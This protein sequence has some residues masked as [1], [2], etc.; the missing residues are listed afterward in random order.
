MLRPA[1][2]IL[3]G[4][5]L[6][7]SLPFVA[8]Q[9][10][11]LRKQSTLPEGWEIINGSGDTNVILIAGGQVWTG[12][13]DGVVL[14]DASTRARLRVPVELA[15]LRHVSAL[16]LDPT[17]TLWVAHDAGV[18][19]GDLETENWQTLPPA[20]L[21]LGGAARA[22]LP[23]PDGTIWI[24]GVGGL[25][26]WREGKI[27]RQNLGQSRLDPVSALLRDDRGRL[28]VGSDAPHRG[29][30]VRIETGNVTDLTEHLPHS[31]VNDMLQVEDG[32]LW[33]ATGFA[34]RGGVATLKPSGWNRPQGTLLLQ[35]AKAR[36]LYMDQDEVLWLGHEYDGA[37]LLDGEAWLQLNASDGLAGE[38]VKVVRQDAQSAYWIGTASGINVIAAGQWRRAIEDR[39]TK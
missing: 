14:F 8:G 35:S 19:R 39:N 9:W 24:G 3:A 21:G 25:V 6:M 20:L 33:V 30:L 10:L 36:S 16:K 2:Q 38:E 4:A 26:A 5:I 7:L 31:S 34:G 11:E 32:T 27:I 29:G 15:P 22:I 12:G 17:G 28:W 1:L 18:T 37:S 13:R 23:E